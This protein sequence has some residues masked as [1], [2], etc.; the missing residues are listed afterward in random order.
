MHRL[1]AFLLMLFV[2]ATAAADAGLDLALILDRSTSMARRS[3]SQD[4]LLRMTLDLLARNA[5]ANRVDHRLAVIGFGSS[6]SVDV[7]FVAVRRDNL[8]EVRQRIDAVHYEDRGDT[9]V[10]DAFT[11]AESLFRALPRSPERR[12]A[13]L[14][15]TD[16]VPYVRDASMSAYRLRLQEFVTRH[17]AGDGITIDVLLLDARDSAL[18]S[19]LARVERVG[20]MPE[21]LLPQA[22]G[23]I[24]RLV[25][26][27]T[28]E[29]APEK[30]NPAVDTLIV[31]PYLDII[32]FDIFRAS[33]DAAIEI[34]PPGS[35]RAIRAGED[36]I[37]SIPVGDVLATLVVPHPAPGEWSIRKSHKDARV[38]VL[39][40]QFFPR[41]VLLRPGE[42]ETQ[43]RC[44][45]VA[46]AY[47]VLDGDG[48]PLEELRGYALALELT[49]AKP[50]HGSS[51][52][53]MERDASLGASG[54][55]SAQDPLCEH[56]G[57]YWTDVRVTTTD[58]KGHRL[59]IFRDRWSGFSVAPS[60]SA[61]CKAALATTTA[62]ATSSRRISRTALWIA[63]VVTGALATA[64]W[65]I[66]RTTKS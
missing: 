54:F 43:R 36:G 44:S 3:R 27:R 45:R 24:A 30:T 56:A 60:T 59:E 19:A 49:L 50:D 15:L 14:L 18:W 25:G 22:H 26:T 66:R 62:L 8:A 6:A 17:V 20:S 53:A 39:S 55:R 13:I 29:S 38:R 1:P 47:R 42:T 16:G 11:V 31:P 58:A 57:R 64:A 21:Q 63:A 46:L 41:G 37:E 40:Q 4:E 28:A 52:V 2:S 51:V 35:T 5:A 12:R 10:L 23:V 32:V 61:D 34:I 9:N 48:N 65:W 7:P 33:R